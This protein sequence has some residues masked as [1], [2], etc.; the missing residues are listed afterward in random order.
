MNEEDDEDELGAVGISGSGD[1]EAGECVVLWD[2][3][4]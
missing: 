3:R 4:D 1:E 2:E